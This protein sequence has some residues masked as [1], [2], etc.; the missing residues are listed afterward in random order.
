MDLMDEDISR[1]DQEHLGIHST[2]ESELLRQ[3]NSLQR[4]ITAFR[5]DRL[6][7]EFPATAGDFATGGVNAGAGGANGSVT[8]ELEA[9]FT[10]LNA[11]AVQK[12][13]RNRS[14]LE[15]A[16]RSTEG[17][18]SRVKRARARTGRKYT[19]ARSLYIDIER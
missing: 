6:V 18:L 13:L 1:R 10:E 15:H 5:K 11:T 16:L 19:P 14:L 3:L 8:D 9:R 2:A 12:I 4:V 17:E 7:S